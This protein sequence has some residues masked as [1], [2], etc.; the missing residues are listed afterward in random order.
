MSLRG[1]RDCG[2]IAQR[3]DELTIG[4]ELDDVRSGKQLWGERYVRKVADLLSV[5]NEIAGEVSKRLHPH[6]SQSDRQKMIAKGSTSDPE[7]YQLYLKGR[8]HT[9]KFTKDEFKKG[10]EFFDQAIARDPNYALAYGGLAYYYILRTIGICPPACL[11]REQK[12]RPKKPWRSTSQMPTATSPWVWCCIGT[13][14]IGRQQSA[15]SNVPLH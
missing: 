11:P 8:Y 3:G 15:S 7:A 12:Q 5:Q 14:G 4:I 10:I 1:N 2:R 6:L 9:S 13:N